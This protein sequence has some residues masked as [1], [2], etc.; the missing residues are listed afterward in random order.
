[1]A[2]ATARSKTYSRLTSAHPP[3]VIAVRMPQQKS[4]KDEPVCL[5]NVFISQALPWCLISTMKTPCISANARSRRARP[6]VGGMLGFQLCTV[7]TCCLLFRVSRIPCIAAPSRSEPLVMRAPT[8][9]LEP[10][11]AVRLRGDR[12]MGKYKR[13]G[14]RVPSKSAVYLG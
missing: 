13:P 4:R 5:F 3:S 6:C 9:G 12:T 11:M 2:H 1:M 14:P 7:C 10:Q 8:P